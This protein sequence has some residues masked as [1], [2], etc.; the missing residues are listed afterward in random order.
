MERNAQSCKGRSRLYLHVRKEQYE[1]LS[2]SYE[3]RKGQ[4]LM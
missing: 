4:T 2:V 1:L 3:G